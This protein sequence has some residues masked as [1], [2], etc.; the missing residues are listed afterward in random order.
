MKFKNLYLILG[1]SLLISCQSK[2]KEDSKNAEPIQKLTEIDALTMVSEIYDTYQNSEEFLIKGIYYPANF[3]SQD[4]N[5]WGKEGQYFKSFNIPASYKNSNNYW[6]LSYDGIYKVNKAL[7]LLDK[8]AK[9]KIITKKLATR[10]KAEC[11]FNRGLIYYYLASNFGNVPIVKG[12]TLAENKEP[13]ASQ[14]TVFNYVVKDFTKA[15]NNLPFTYSEKKDLGRV[16]KGAALAYLGESYMWLHQYKKAITSFDK[17]KGHYELMS[18]YLDINA[19]KHQNNKESIL[20]IQFN[21]N[22]NL[23]WGRDNY[24][25]FIQSFTLPTEVGGAGLAFA[26]PKYAKSF[27]RNDRR[28]KATVIGPNQKHPDASINIS[29][30]NS[31]QEKFKGINTLGTRKNPWL[32]D[33]GKRS[34]YYSVKSWRAPDP[35]AT[36]SAVFSKANVILMRYGQILL[37]LAE[38]KLKTG[39]VKGAQSLINKVRKRAGLKPVFKNDMMPVLL[40]EYRH[41]LAGEFSLWYVLRRT[42]NQIEYIK[43]NFNIDIPKGHDLL[44]IPSEQLHLNKSLK[45]NFGY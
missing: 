41:E 19:F 16:T 8:M 20:E 22:D 27:E 3:L 23:G 29:S 28:A 7:I 13:N 40:N 17:L 38:C 45:Q 25:T 21:G 34:G 42:G 26:N 43:S 32:G 30:Y 39:D 31:V 14:D 35:N 37:D 18:N 33:D 44:P 15:K 12:E 10:L 36:A 4:F 2:Q 5:L 24:S 1:L 9:D 11:Y 6:N